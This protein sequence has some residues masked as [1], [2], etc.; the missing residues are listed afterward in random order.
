MSTLYLERQDQAVV[1]RQISGQ[2]LDIPLKMRRKV[3]IG[4]RVFTLAGR[5]VR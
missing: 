3:A 2:Q 1:G 4:H 5:E